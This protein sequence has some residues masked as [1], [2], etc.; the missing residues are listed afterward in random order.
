[1]IL[2]F[3]FPRSVVCHLFLP[4]SWL[5]S[6]HLMKFSGSVMVLVLLEGAFL[7]VIVIGD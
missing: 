6:K 1:L 4:R 5:E 3:W 2:V 7:F